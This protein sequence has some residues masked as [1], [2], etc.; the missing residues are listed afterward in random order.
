MKHGLLIAAIALRVLSAAIGYWKAA[1][2]LLF[3]LSPIGPHLRWTHAYTGSPEHPR[4]VRCDYIGARGLITP[5]F[6]PDCPL[7]VWLDA[8]EWRP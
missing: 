2:I 3:F 1:L 8:R 6:A 7:F 4:Y 5:P